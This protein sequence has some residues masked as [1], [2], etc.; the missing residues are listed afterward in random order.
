MSC[1]SDYPQSHFQTILC[2]EQSLLKVFCVFRGEEVAAYWQAFEFAVSHSPKFLAL[3]GS[4]I[5]NVPRLFYSPFPLEMLKLCLNLE[6]V[7]VFAVEI[8]EDDLVPILKLFL[9]FLRYE[10]I[11]IPYELS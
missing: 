5:E 10:G 6:D 4:G 11:S 1:S 3:V 9:L 7:I 8:V 2:R